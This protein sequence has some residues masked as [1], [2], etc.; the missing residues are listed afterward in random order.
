[1]GK[2]EIGLQKRGRI[3]WIDKQVD[4]RRIRE[5]TGTGDLAEARQY[6]NFR[7]DRLRREGV[8]GERPHRTFE[9][10]AARYLLENQRKR[11]ISRDDQALR[12]VMPYIGHLE[13]AK[14]H[15]GKLQTFVEDRLKSGVAASTINRDLSPVRQVLKAAARQWF[16]PN[17]HPWLTAVPE[18]PRL[19]VVGGRAKPITLVE[20]N[21]LL[22]AL[23]DYLATMALFAVNTGCRRGE[24][25]ELRWSWRIAG[26]MAFLIPPDFHKTGEKTGTRLIV[27]NSTAW[28]VV[29]EQMGNHPEFVFTRGNRPVKTFYG[30][31]W[32]QARA[33]AGLEH[34]R[35][36]DLRHTFATRLAACGV[37][38]ADVGLLLGHVSN[39]VTT[40]YIAPDVER[41]LLQ[42]EKVVGM[43]RE[44][45]LRV[46][47]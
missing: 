5:S 31:A 19:P 25:M 35:V 2:R 16:H 6:L 47:G 15:F 38:E 40:G 4:R 18:I 22:L 44:P 46:V 29:E 11:S 13:L 37:T 12:S 30:R 3:W 24:V 23:P 45:V 8:F 17:G 28:S 33:E 42:A 36:H 14:V 39:K 26:M 1:M 32:K 7:L 41:L 20:Q 43:K 9:Q 10:A 27:C 34:V 21:R